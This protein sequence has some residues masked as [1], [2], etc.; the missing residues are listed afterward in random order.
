MIVE[1]LDPGHSH[2]LANDTNRFICGARASI[3]SARSVVLRGGA[4]YGGLGRDDGAPAAAADR[5][6]REVEVHQRALTVCGQA[7]PMHGFRSDE[8]SRVVPTLAGLPETH[9]A[10]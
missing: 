10:T 5:A 4:N 7:V 3:Q 1:R 9:E 8:L 2:G 6:T